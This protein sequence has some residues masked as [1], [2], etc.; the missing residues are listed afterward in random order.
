ML[1]VWMFPYICFSFLVRLV[2]SSWSSVRKAFTHDELTCRHIRLQERMRQ[3]CR[4]SSARHGRIIEKQ[5]V[6]MDLKGVPVFVEWACFKSLKE[7]IGIDEGF[8]P[9]TLKNLF[10]INAPVY[11]TALWAIVKPWLDPLT[12]QKI[13]ILGENYYPTLSKYID[14]DVLPVEYGGKNEN[15]YWTSPQNET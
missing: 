2:G 11:F 3:K 10:V 14:D 1:L 12:L 15:F 5:V 6:I 8:Y 9:E 4:D 13:Q 7:V